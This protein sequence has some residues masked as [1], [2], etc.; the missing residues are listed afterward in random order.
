M[1]TD[2]RWNRVSDLFLRALELEASRRVEFLKESCGDDK[3]VLLEVTSLLEAHTEAGTFFE[4]PMVPE[5]LEAIHEAEEPLQPGEILGVYQI[6]K[7]IARGG[8]GAV[9]LA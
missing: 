6:V 9:Y 3:E 2:D 7:M 8:M 4:K 5:A 1:P